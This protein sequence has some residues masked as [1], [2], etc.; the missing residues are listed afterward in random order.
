VAGL[1]FEKWRNSFMLDAEAEGILRTAG[2]LPETALRS[3]WREGVAPTVAAVVA[4]GRKAD[5]K[6]DGKAGN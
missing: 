2:M 6:T 4:S 1:S 3:F 5:G